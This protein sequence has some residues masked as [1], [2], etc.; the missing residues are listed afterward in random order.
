MNELELLSRYREV[1]PIDPTLVDATIQ[2]ILD[3]PDRNGTSLGHSFAPR[4]RPLRRMVL[5]GA[6]VAAAVTAVAIGGL[7][8][9]ASHH[10]APKVAGMHGAELATYVVHHSLAALETAS[11][12]LEQ[13][14]DRDPRGIVTTWRGPHQFLVEVPGKNAM[15]ETWAPDGS[16]TVLSID[17]QHQTW[18]RSSFPAPPPPIGSPPPTLLNVSPVDAFNGAEPS[19][20]TIAAWFRQPGTQLVGTATINGTL[21][22][23]LRIPALD[24]NG[25]PVSGEIITAWVAAN[26]YLPVRMVREMPAGQGV[27]NGARVTIPAFKATEDFTWEPANTQAI[28]V[29]DLKPPAGFQQITDPALQPVSP[30]Y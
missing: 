29:F 5:A 30:G 22:Y 28:A 7:A 21:A 14:V 25:K 3:V 18:Y 19:A 2:A 20:S 23:E 16:S 1:E 15:L 13:V 6:S 11:G 24:A 26:T 10:P 17:Y 9:S 4:R 12:Y 8:G 27:D